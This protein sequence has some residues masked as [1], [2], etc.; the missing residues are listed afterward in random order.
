MALS[1]SLF[2]AFTALVTTFV[3]GLWQPNIAQPTPTSPSFDLRSVTMELYRSPTCGCCEEYEKY[4]RAEGAAVK[5]IEVERVDRIKDRLDI[6]RSMWSCHT[7]TV[8]GY[9]VEGHIPVEAVQKL[10]AEK[11]EVDGIAL[12]GMP[13][14][15]PGMGGAK[16]HPFQ[17]YSITDG[18]VSEFMVV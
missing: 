3:F 17:I 18:K 8:G 12:P 9:F 4:L 6:P 1:I 13:H 7:I 11:P 5:S 15:S 2:A 10:L 16:S 14:G